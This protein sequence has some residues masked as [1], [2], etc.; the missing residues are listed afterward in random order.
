MVTRCCVL[1]QDQDAL[2]PQ[3]AEDLAHLGHGGAD[4]RADVGHGR[5]AAHR[6]EMLVDGE[7]RSELKLHRSRSY[8]TE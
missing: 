6:G 5:A 1:L 3:S 4:A 7:L 2:L 8:R